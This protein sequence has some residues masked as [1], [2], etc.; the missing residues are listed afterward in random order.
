MDRLKIEF[1]DHV[2]HVQLARP[3]KINALDAQTIQELVLAEDR[4]RADSRCRVVVL[5][6]SGRGFCSGLDLDT[7]SSASEGKAQGI[8]I[9]DM[10]HGSANIA[11]HAVLQWRNLPIPVLAAVHGVAYGGGFQLALGADIRIVHPEARLAVMEVK[12]GLIP[13]MAGMVLLPGLVSPDVQADLVYT[14]RVIDGAEALRL[15]L[16]TRLS[17]DLITAAM[18]LASQIAGQSP[19]AVRAA[20]RLMMTVGRENVP[21]AEATEQRA[22]FGKPN[23]RLANDTSYGLSAR[24][25][26]R[27]VGTAHKMGRKIKAGLVCIN[28]LAYGPNLPIPV[29]FRHHRLTR[30]EQLSA[31]LSALEFEIPA[32]A[33]ERL[34]SA[35]R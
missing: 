34:E 9:T 3:E 2:A 30:G 1:S 22:L 16:A 25:W 29:D 31:N 6:G 12:W 35:S 33:R 27:D 26:T 14:G 5:S 4:L 11:Q 32:P 21:R 10:T 7:L 24:I 23:Q 8:N 19:D 20:K 13:D 18:D 17:E 15:G 28:G